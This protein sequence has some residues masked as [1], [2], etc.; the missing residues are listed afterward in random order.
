[1]ADTNPTTEIGFSYEYGLDIDLS[2]NDIPKWQ[3]MRFAKV[4]APTANAKTVDGATYDDKGADHPIKTGESWELQ[5]TVQQHRLADGHYLPEV[6]ALM[7]ATAPDAKGNKASVHVRFYDKP[8]SGTPNPNDAYEG[9]ATVSMN[10]ANTGVNEEGGWQFT[11]TGQGPRKK[12]VNP[13]IGSSKPTIAGITPTGKKVGEQVTLS[14]V[15]FTGATAV[16][17]GS[18]TAAFTVVNDATIV[19]TVPA[20]ATGSMQVTVTTSGGTSAGTS[21]MVAS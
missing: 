17:F 13:L 9:T 14:G 16:K 15:G 19:A 21:Y 20:T 11:L 4:I 10:R 7:A 12:I 5:L 18:L 1:M 2:D 6:E 3:P 8:A